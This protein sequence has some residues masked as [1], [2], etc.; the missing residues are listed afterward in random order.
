MWAPLAP[1]ARRT[2]SV[3]HVG[4]LHACCA[5]RFEQAARKGAKRTDTR[6]RARHASDTRGTVVRGARGAHPAALRA[7]VPARPRSRAAAQRLCADSR[8]R[9]AAP[10]AWRRR[11]ARA[12]RP[13]ARKHGSCAR[14]LARPTA[15]AA[16]TAPRKQAVFRASSAVATHPAQSGREARAGVE[17]F[18]LLARQL[19]TSADFTH[20]A[21]AA[22]EGARRRHCQTCRSAPPPLPCL[23]GSE[24][25]ASRTH[26]R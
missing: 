1:H 14:G 13:A 20:A 7:T 3:R 23:R 6:P 8:L 2:G 19:S 17:R 22:N 12:A 4:V 26:V 16:D 9:S 15:E 11:C 21:S 10:R 25:N 24:P 5:Q 18:T